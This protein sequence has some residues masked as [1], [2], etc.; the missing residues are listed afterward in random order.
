MYHVNL[1]ITTQAN[2]ILILKPST[3]DVLMICYRTMAM[4]TSV[5]VRMV[6]LVNVVI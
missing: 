4:G 3:K 6:S 2:Y 1:L 5:S